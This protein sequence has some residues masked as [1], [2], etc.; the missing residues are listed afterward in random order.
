MRYYR[1]YSLDLDDNHIIDV[2]DF[3]ANN[4]VAAI[5]KAGPPQGGVARELW[6]HDRKVLELTR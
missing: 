6:N 2:R 5:V 1:L 4:D 3:R